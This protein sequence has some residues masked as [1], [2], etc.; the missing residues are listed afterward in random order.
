[1][2]WWGKVIGGAFGFMLGGPL[3]AMLGAALGHNFDRGMGSANMLGFHGPRADIEKIQS[4]FFTATFSIMGFVAKADGR[5][6]E[7]EISLAR[8]VMAQ[9]RL[10]EQQQKAAIALF[11]Q[12]KKKDFPLDDCLAQFRR[13]CHQSGNLLQ[14]FM[15]IQIA[16]AMADGSVDAAEDRALAHIA[17]ALGFS[18]RD[19]RSL[20]SRLQAQARFHAQAEGRAKTTPAK[21]LA[22][23]YKLLGVPKTASDEEVKKAYRRLMNQHHPDKLV[24]KGLPQEMM[25]IATQKTQDIRNAYELIRNARKS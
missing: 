25:D 13:E 9:M 22:D 1:M 17:A 14:M 19:Y 6:S 4:A 16:T 10:N 5:V 2:S 23:A 20:L 12:G 21:A 7:R 11:Q 3:G 15:E 18:A 24:A 8:Q